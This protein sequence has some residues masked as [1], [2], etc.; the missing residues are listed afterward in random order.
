[1]QK[2]MTTGLYG[3]HAAYLRNSSK[4]KLNSEALVLLVGPWCLGLCLVG[5]SAKNA[6]ENGV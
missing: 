3:L 2:S 4:L 6:K 5:E 1:M